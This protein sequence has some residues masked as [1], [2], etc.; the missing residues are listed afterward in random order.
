MIAGVLV[1]AVRVI[2]AIRRP[3][4]GREIGKESA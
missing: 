4:S 1:N 3:A 2:L